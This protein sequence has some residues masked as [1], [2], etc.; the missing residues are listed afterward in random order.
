MKLKKLA[1]AVGVAMS[2]TTA[3]AQAQVLSFEDDDIDFALTS[4]LAPKPFSGPG[5]NLA[6]GDVLVAAFEIPAFTFGGVG[7][8]PA[9]QELTGV[10]AIQITGIA[11]AL[12]TFSAYTGGLNAVLAL[13]TNPDPVI[14]GCDAGSGCTIAMWFSGAPGADGSGDRNLELNRSVLPASNC[15]SLADCIDQ[16]SRGELFQVDGFTGDPDEYWEAFLLRAGAGNIGAVRALGSSILTAAFN[17]AQTTIF[18]AGTAIG[19]IDIETNQPC[20][21]SAGLNNCVSGMTLSGTI[22]GGSGL[23]NG[24]FAH[25]DF[26]GFKVALQVSEPATLALLGVGLLGFGASRRRSA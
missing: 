20:A 8:I 5:A 1:A 12:V 16:A 9:G 21:T 6:V 22:T 11:G 2:L 23:T 3:V 25:S 14:P 10:S 17:A 26:D 19:P 7:A 18:Q 13:G 15:T 4:T 24:A